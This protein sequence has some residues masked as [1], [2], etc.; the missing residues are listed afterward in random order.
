MASFW[1]SIL[2]SRGGEA[3]GNARRTL[4]RW[5]TH[6][7]F[8]LKAMSQPTIDLTLRTHQGLNTRI[9]ERPGLSLAPDE[10]DALVSQLRVV[11][12]KT[13]PREELTYGIFS[14]E[15]ERLSG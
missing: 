9:V 14:G 12:A 6:A 1:N 8:W 15:A 10:L 7:G 3:V 4:S 5:R 13:L 2:A 11:A